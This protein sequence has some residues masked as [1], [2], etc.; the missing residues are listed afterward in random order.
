MNLNAGIVI[1]GLIVIMP[2][3]AMTQGDFGVMSGTVFGPGGETVPDMPIQATHAVTGEYERTRSAADGQFRLSNLAAG[4]YTITISAPCCVYQSYKSD[5]IIVAVGDTKTFE[6]RLVEGAS[7][8]TVGDDPGV[9][10][11]AVR[12]RQEIPD[13]P[14]PR[15]TNGK[16]DFSG[17]WLI[18]EEAFP[19]APNAYPWAQELFAE[20]IANDLLEHPHTRCLPGD[21]PTPHAVPPFM[22]KFVQKA[23][24]LVILFEDTP[25]FRQ[26]FLDGR[27]HPD[28]PNPSWVGHSIGHW[29]GDV[30]VVDTVGFNDRGW[31]GIYPRTE[32]LHLVERYTRTDYGHIDLEVTIEDPKVFEE[33]WIRNF[34]L[35]LAPQEELMEYVCENNKWAQPYGN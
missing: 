3:V 19:Q 30:L 27:K 16:P 8:N 25:G 4:S 2:S 14:I 1:L 29:D 5:E 12:A 24:L 13:L 15:M 26:I 34:P 10:A 21:A 18:G 23:E 31:M 9:I 35:D 28:D 22:G 32:E 11:A 6:I 17:L 33:P 7:F 20:R